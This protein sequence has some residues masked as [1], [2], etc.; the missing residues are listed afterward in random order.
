MAA[1][2]EKKPSLENILK[3]FEQAMKDI[4]SSKFEKALKLFNEIQNSNL[5]RPEL[6]EKAQSLSKLCERKLDKSDGG[7]TGDSPE[8]I[9]DYGIFCHNNG[10][11]EEALAHFKK[12][13]DAAGEKLDYVYYAMAATHAAQGQNDDALESLKIAVDLN[14]T[15]R[16]HAANDPDFNELAEDDQFRSLLDPL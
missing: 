3:K 16:I 14:E 1:R 12:S 10:D 11:F 6:I 4:Y 13:L 9:Y 7:V 8:V 15:C 2:K 5:N